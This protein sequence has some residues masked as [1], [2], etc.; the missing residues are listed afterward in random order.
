[1]LYPRLL[2]IVYMIAVAVALSGM[3]QVMSG[4]VR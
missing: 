3:L 1:M 4:T 2:T